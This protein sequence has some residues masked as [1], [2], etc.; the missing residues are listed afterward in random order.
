[1][2]SFNPKKKKLSW[3]F[4]L[5]KT[6]TLVVCI[7]KHECLST[8]YFPFERTTSIQSPCLNQAISCQALSSIVYNFIFTT[9]TVTRLSVLSKSI[10]IGGSKNLAIGHHKKLLYLLY[11][12]TF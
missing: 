7:F 9:L 8:N 2:P 4:S 5:P 3:T 1:M 10:S 12:L 11:H 6:I